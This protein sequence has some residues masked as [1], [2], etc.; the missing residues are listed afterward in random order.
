MSQSESQLRCKKLILASILCVLLLGIF[1]VWLYYPSILFA[2]LKA[3]FVGDDEKQSIAKKL[4]GSE[5]GID[6]ALSDLNIYG[7]QTKGMYE[8]ILYESENK[9]LVEQKLASYI[10]DTSKGNSER[11]AAVKVLYYLSE[12]PAVLLDYFRLVKDPGGNDIYMARRYLNTIVKDQ[13]IAVDASLSIRMT[14]V[15]FEQLIK[16][17]FHKKGLED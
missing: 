4:S 12:D 5:H 10:A 6:L 8:V 14:E 16:H 9:D 17:K 11:S 7:G 15:E 2:L 3:D 1:L 13:R